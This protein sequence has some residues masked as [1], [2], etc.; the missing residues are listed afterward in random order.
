[1]TL[2][3]WLAA[4]DGDASGFWFQSLAANLFFPRAQ[5]WG[6]FAAVARAD[7]NFARAHFSEP[8]AQDP[9]LGDPGGTFIWTGGARGRLSSGTR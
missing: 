4:A 9:I 2:D 1:M 6:E 5:A 3:S 7:T 8:Q